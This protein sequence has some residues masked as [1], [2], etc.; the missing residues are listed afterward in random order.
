MTESDKTFSIYLSDYAV[1]EIKNQLEKRGTL[2]A[3]LRL[4]IKGGGCS[5]LSY[6]I[7]FEDD[8]PREKDI[9]FNFAG[10]QVIIDKKSII[11]LNGTTLEWENTLLRKGFKFMN[12]NEKSSCGC[13]SSFNV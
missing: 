12:P 11:Y 3:S 13:G 9:I 8:P 1:Q 7:S 6:H 2:S 4:G 5:G 10:L